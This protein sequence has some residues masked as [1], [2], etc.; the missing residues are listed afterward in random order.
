MYSVQ[1]VFLRGHILSS[2]TSAFPNEAEQLP[3][4]LSNILPEFSV[5]TQQLNGSAARIKKVGLKRMCIL[6]V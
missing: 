6:L 4:P 2:H 1:V 5:A 3:H